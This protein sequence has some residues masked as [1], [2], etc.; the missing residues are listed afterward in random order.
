MD[1]SSRSSHR[2]EED[3]CSDIYSASWLRLDLPRA[4]M[5]FDP[6]WPKHP[7]VLMALVPVGLFSG[8]VTVSFIRLAGLG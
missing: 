6:E 7:R 8:T 5:S 3:R 2:D 1:A 4:V